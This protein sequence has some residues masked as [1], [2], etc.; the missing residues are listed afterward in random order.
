MIMQTHNNSLAGLPARLASPLAAS[1]RL[2]RQAAGEEP[3]TAERILFIVRSFCVS[4][5]FS[6]P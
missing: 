2:H 4:C 1:P 6:V 3:P 5:P